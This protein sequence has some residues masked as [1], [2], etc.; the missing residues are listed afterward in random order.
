MNTDKIENAWKQNRDCDSLLNLNFPA[1]ATEQDNRN[2]GLP[3]PVVHVHNLT[4]GVMFVLYKQWYIIIFLFISVIA[5]QTPSFYLF[6]F[7]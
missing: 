1:S 6:L 2:K 7:Q 5:F 4:T 3:G